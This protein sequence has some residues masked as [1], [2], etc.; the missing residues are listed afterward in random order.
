MVSLT[1]QDI[2]VCQEVIQ[3]MATDL[4][5]LDIG[6]LT[7]AITSGNDGEEFVID[8]S[9]GMV[10]LNCRQDTQLDRENKQF[11]LLQVAARDS[12]GNMVSAVYS[13]D[14]TTL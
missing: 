4:D 11:Y 6:R 1:L 14:G 3:L 7:Y 5:S 2:G 10:H 9:T 13:Q 8:A 12:A